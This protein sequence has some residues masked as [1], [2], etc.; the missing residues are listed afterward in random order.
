MKNKDILIEQ[1]FTEFWH[2]EQLHIKTI[3]F[4]VHILQTEYSTILL[5]NKNEINC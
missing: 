1:N 2:Y 5:S 4:A 3:F